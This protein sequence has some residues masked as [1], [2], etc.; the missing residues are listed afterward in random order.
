M[1]GVGISNGGW[2]K[3]AKQLIYCIEI[4]SAVFMSLMIYNQIKPDAQE[5]WAGSLGISPLE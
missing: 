4:C 2:S 5:P 1:N 3:K